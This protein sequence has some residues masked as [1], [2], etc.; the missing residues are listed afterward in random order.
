MEN[1]QEQI[2]T[3]VKLQ[4]LD[5]QI[6]G[7]RQEK[8]KKPEIKEILKDEFAQQGELLK[9]KQ[10]QLKVN[11]LKHKEHELDLG[12]K[13]EDVKKKQSQLL[14]IKTNK[15][16]VAMQ[17]E[18]EGLKADNSI[19]EDSILGLMD[20]ID[21]LKQELEKEKQNLTL[22]E[23]KFKD[24]SVKVDQEVKEIDQKLLALDGQRKEIAV[25]ID[26][27]LLT[28]YERILNAKAG[29]ALVP[30]VGESCGGC[31]QIVPPQVVN[32]VRMKDRIVT[33]QFCARLLYYS[34]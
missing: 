20:T 33:C 12:K 19:L 25:L 21:T 5:S 16:Y 11:Q 31:H 29:L 9:A 18:M 26:K 13:E 23:K 8:E 24:E 3:L 34:E 30:A 2:V 10:E 17:R 15:E 1:V 4:E 22:E 28:Q 6:Y 27:N 14:Q 7:L 32:E